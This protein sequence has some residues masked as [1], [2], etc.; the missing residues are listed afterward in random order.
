MD[1]K[2]KFWIWPVF[3]MILIETFGMWVSTQWVASLNKYPVEFGPIL[4]VLGDTPIYPPMFL[5]WW[6]N[7]GVYSPKS[8]DLASYA[9]MGGT[10]L[11]MGF[12]FVVS[13]I[14]SRTKTVATS[15]GTARWADSSDIEKSGLLNNPGVILGQTMGD[16]KYLRHNGPEH[17]MIMAPTRSGKGVGIIIP[18]LL[19]WVHSVLVMDIKSEN[20][21]K[22]AGFRKEKL[23]NIVLKFDPTASD[24]SSVRFNPLSEIR[25]RTNNEVRD[26]QNVADMLVDPQ[27][28]GQLDHWA[29]TGHA[30]LVGVILN[31]LY[32]NENA[33]LSDVAT[34]LSDP[35]QSFEDTLE[36]MLNTQ[37]ES[38]TD[39]F[40]QI[41]RTKTTTHPT[42]AQAAREL[43][44]KSENER[45]GVLS[46]AMSFLGLYRD[47][48][49]AH[50]TAI[51][52]FCIQDLMNS[53]RPVSLYLVIPPSDINRLK[54]LLRLILNQ[55][56]RRLTETMSFKDGR[57][58]QGYKHRL[59]LLIDEFP[60]LGRLDTFEAA[61]AFIAGYG[62][63]AMLV[64]QSLKQLNKAYTDNN[65]IIDNCHIRIVYTPN[66]EKT[67]EFI[68]KLLGTK[69]E[70][71]ENQSISGNRIN[72]YLGK[73]TVSTQESQRALL[74]PGEL[75][76]F[77][78][79]QEIVFV[80]GTPPIRAKKVVYYQDK[81]FTVRQ[82]AAP[83]ESDRIRPAPVVLPPPVF[84]PRFGA[85]EVTEYTDGDETP[86]EDVYSQSNEAPGNMHELDMPEDHPGEIES[87]FP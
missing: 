39:L 71:I 76:V 81:N 87:M 44:N 66:D 22:T 17:I 73:V 75:S 4:Y 19:S 41:Y 29:K 23:K 63:K 72:A 14:R 34:F 65:S 58:V 16:N 11:A 64:V 53:A 38:T 61:L 47:P 40:E 27:G 51:S 33:T 13:T 8:F 49:I 26:V 83:P 18:T 20:W 79:D 31:L 36:A 21:N 62:L 80:A 3:V 12:L 74:T 85:V 60:A 77:P 78:M 45:S 57:E 32:F 37:H 50:N 86:P 35:E 82:M 30:L 25:L 67:P 54:P 69:T 10:I 46:T 48:V 7:Y 70:I 2:F 28:T 42:V 1:S 15:H 84:P 59:L 43:L 68:S 56:V 55:F 9:T 5:V 24:G 6:W 52:E